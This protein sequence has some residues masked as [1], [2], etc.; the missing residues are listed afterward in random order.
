VTTEQITWR[1]VTGGLPDA[2]TNVLLALAD[3][4]TCEGFNDGLWE[5]W[6]DKPPLFRDVCAEPLDR[7]VVTHRAEMPKGPNA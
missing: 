4:T 1:P 3:G 5:Q 2:E 6:D 7:D